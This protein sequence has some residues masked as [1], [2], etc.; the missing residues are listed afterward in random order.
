MYKDSSCRSSPQPP[1]PT[2]N[3]ADP[4]SDRAATTASTNLTQGHPPNTNLTSTTTTTATTTTTTT[5]TQGTTTTTAN[6]PPHVHSSA[7][8]EDDE[9]DGFSCPSE[10]SSDSEYEIRSRP[11][12]T[13]TTSTSS[14][15]TTTAAG[16]GAGGGAPNFGLTA[17]VGGPCVRRQR[18]TTTTARRQHHHHRH[19]NSDVRILRKIGYIASRVRFLARIYA[20]FKLVNPYTPAKQ[21]R[22]LQDIILKHSIVDPE[23]ELSKAAEASAKPRPS[24]TP[25]VRSLNSTSSYSGQ[26]QTESSFEDDSVTGTVR[27]KS[28]TSITASPSLLLLEDLLVQLYEDR[29]NKVTLIRRRR[30]RRSSAG[31]ATG[32]GTTGGS[33][34]LKKPLNHLIIM[35]SK[36]TSSSVERLLQ[37]DNEDEGGGGGP[38]SHTATDAGSVERLAKGGNHI[39]NANITSSSQQQQQQQQRNSS[40][41]LQPIAGG[42]ENLRRRRASDCT[43]HPGQPLSN[44]LQI[45]LKNNN[46]TKFP[47]HR[48]SCGGAG[49]HLLAA[50]SIANRQTL[51]LSKSCGN[52]DASL[53][54]SNPA[55]YGS[56]DLRSNTTGVSSVG[57][58][59][60]MTT[61]GTTATSMCGGGGG[62][63]GIGGGGGAG[64]QAMN[65]NNEYSIVQLNN[66][67]IQCHFNDEDFKALVKDLKRKVEYTERMNWLCLSKRPMGPQCRKSSLPKHQEVK[68]RFLEICD[69]TFSEEVRNALRLPAFDSYEWSDADII[70]L[71]QTMFI[72][73]GFIEKFNI[74]LD[75]LREWLY[76]VYKHYNE[77]P[78]HNFRHCFCVAQMMY[79][80]T[81][82][83]NLLQRLGDLE[84][85]ILLVSCI[86][87]DL[88]HPGYNNI[89]QINA[90]TEL[91]LRYNDI[92]PLENHHCSIAFRLLEHPD[93][94]IFRNFSRE[95]F[96]QIREGIIRCILA[97]DMAR[98]NEILTQFKEVTPVFDYSNR[99]H[100]NL[101][102]MILIKVADISN[103][104]RPMDVAEPWLDRLLQEFFAQSAAEKTEG[105]PVTPFMD[106]DKVSK[107][108]SQV[109]FIGLVLLPLFEALGE[110][111]PEVVDMIIVPVRVA[112]DYYKRLN[113]A[114]NKSRKSLADSISAAA[115]ENTS[116]GSDANAASTSTAGGSTGGGT[117]GAGGSNTGAT[118]SGAGNS[119]GSISPQMPRS[120]SGISVKSRRSIPS[121]KS[122]SRTSVDEPGGMP[123]ELHDL[124]EGSE[125]GDSE[126]ATEVD[127]AEKTSKFKVDTEGTSNRSKSSHS[128][129]RKSSREKRP[130]MI[131]EMCSSGSGQRIRNSYGNIHGYHSNRSHF[132]SNR[133]V[134]LDQ[135]STNNRRLSDGLQQVISDSNVFYNRHNRGSLE[136]S[137]V[138][139][140]LVEDM[141]MNATGIVTVAQSSGGRVAGGYLQS[142]TSP[143]VPNTEGVTSINGS[144]LQ[145]PAAG[146]NATN[147]TASNMQQQQQQQN[148]MC[149]NTFSNGNISPTQQLQHQQLQQ[150][151]Q[152][153]PPRQH[154]CAAAAAAAAAAANSAQNGLTTSTTSETPAASKHSWKARLKQFSDYFSFSFDKSS[155][156]FNSTRSSP[157]S[158]RNNNGTQTGGQDAGATYIDPLTGKPTTMC[159]TISNSL[160]SPGLRQ[161][162]IS[163]QHDLMS[164]GRHRAYSLDVPCNRSNPRYSS[165]SGGGG[166][167]SRKSSR[168]D[169]TVTG[170]ENNSN[171]TLHSSSGGGSDMPTCMPPPIRIGSVDASD[172]ILI[173]TGVLPN[174]TSATLTPATLGEP[175][176]PS[177]SIDLGLQSQSSSAEPPKI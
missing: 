89:Y 105:L 59:G 48:G 167:S 46:C 43:P 69:T 123:A 11:S 119:G 111:V 68:K 67:I 106:P 113:D 29:R 95:A 37:L 87:H 174:A 31:Q 108:G 9:E 57:G 143:I 92:S 115:S 156:R 153:Q 16:S 162:H 86:C 146:P 20:D 120:Q 97:T 101:L 5:T 130:S 39:Y 18:S 85:L 81:R 7:T 71:M 58:N 144:S 149:I 34:Q 107:P 142:N 63:S 171:N 136:A 1:P 23:R 135:Y 152:Q 116:G 112:L 158:V 114:Q 128:A 96:N 88:D 154:C 38:S 22:L 161:K 41:F 139:C 74:P 145:T 93:C 8:V 160:Q 6:V 45:T 159:C 61:A 121:Q 172:T 124:P 15:S 4:D 155:K 165:S 47:L 104:A 131:G 75:T 79:A 132:S 25:S 64:S 19:S 138:N 33:Q 80:I 168:H 148:I 70:H 72:E 170:E 100:I 60:S 109:R 84:C 32:G 137:T 150:Q 133:A 90:R 76:E 21:R 151:H 42:E 169:G 44:Q 24:D 94:N 13:S 166:D 176:E 77:V 163:H 91:A 55:L 141:N 164:A 102:C 126:T 127:V 26:Q 30:S 17:G 175:P 49:D 56:G 99:A 50:N 134:S 65:G 110:L 62:G 103:E 125:S 177:L 157:C 10:S 36:T 83:A 40:I 27:R 173:T 54:N 2:T 66:T 3:V 140:R 98:H 147:T 12:T 118:S 122:A 51:I 28:S 82:Q 35:S 73:L 14:S 52:V 129:S 53:G 117:G 78:F